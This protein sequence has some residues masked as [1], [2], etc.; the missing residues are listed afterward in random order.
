MKF[1]CTCDNGFFFLML[2]IDDK[3]ES[4]QLSLNWLS[5]TNQCGKP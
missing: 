2:L 5:K 1:E 3:T 4:C